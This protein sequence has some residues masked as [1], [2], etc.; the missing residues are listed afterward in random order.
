MANELKTLQDIRSSNSLNPV[1]AAR[2]T[3][4]EQ[5]GGAGNSQGI[6]SSG[7]GEIVDPNAFLGYNTQ[8]AL[9]MY[10]EA[11]RPA[12][13]ATKASIPITEQAYSQRE[14]S[15]SGQKEPLKQRYQSIIDELK[16]KES[17]DTQSATLNTARE[18]GKRG[19]PL[20]SG[21]YDVGLTEAT[22]PIREF[23]TGQTKDVSLNQ[24]DALREIDSLLASL[25]IEKAQ[26]LNQIQQAIAALESGS[27]KDA[28]SQAFNLL[29]MQRQQEEAEANRSLQSRGLDL[30]QKELDFTMNQP[31]VSDPLKDAQA[32]YYLAQA[33]KLNRTPVG[34]SGGGASFDPTSDFDEFMSMWNAQK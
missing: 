3:Q 11:N 8:K 18:F 23:Y 33:S 27:S 7:L 2:L 6:A 14:S 32:Q 28:I 20:S 25:P 1:Q 12:V 21:S 24:E 17:V 29:T 31:K 9:E 19:V 5:Q 16:R 10:R 22:R 26:S 15:L 4:L 30:Q 13:D 34:G